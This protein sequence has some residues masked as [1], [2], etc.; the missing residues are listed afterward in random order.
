MGVPVTQAQ[1][2]PCPEKV[3][4]QRHPA[5]RAVRMQGAQQLQ[6]SLRPSATPCGSLKARGASSATSAPPA[7]PQHPLPEH[8]NHLR[9]AGLRPAT[10]CTAL[11]QQQPSLPR[12]ARSCMRRRPN[13]CKGIRP[14]RISV[15][16]LKGPWTGESSQSRTRSALAAQQT[17]STQD[18][19]RRRTGAW[20]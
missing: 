15:P 7:G 4:T 16:V 12:G 14:A 2:L 17:L 9:R 3:Q 1:P 5:A 19:H 20:S 18:L 13:R 11:Q 10:D 8:L 6:S